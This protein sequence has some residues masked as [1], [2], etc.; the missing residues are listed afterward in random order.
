MAREISYGLC[1]VPATR[2]TVKRP[3]FGV[4]MWTS[5][6]QFCY[7]IEVESLSSLECY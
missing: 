7:Y 3:F 2:I 5:L 6:G 1:G 4:V